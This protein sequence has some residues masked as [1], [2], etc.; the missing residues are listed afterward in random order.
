VAVKLQFP[1]LRTQFHS[2]L[3]FCR[4]LVYIGDKLLNLN[5]YDKI[6]FHDIYDTFKNANIDELDFRKEVING[7]ICMDNFKND[8]QVYI[9]LYIDH[10]CSER[11][12]T[13]EFVEGVKIND[14]E[15]IKKMGIDPKAA[16][17]LMINTLGTMVF[18]HGHVHC[19]A[20]PGNLMIRVS[21]TLQNSIPELIVIDHGFYR[22]YD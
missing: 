19:D 5:G 1:N 20:H 2:D 13:L 14:V 6:N 15:G 16:A 10:L 11:V 3:N 18:K 17:K 7:K 21:P 9:P 4:T 22:K 12:I 8:P